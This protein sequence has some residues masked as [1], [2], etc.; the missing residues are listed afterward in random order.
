MKVKIY[1]E[2]ADENFRAIRVGDKTRRFFANEI[3]E[4]QIQKFL[5]ENPKVKI[6]HDQ[7]QSIAIVP[8][9]ADWN[10]TSTDIHW[11]MEKPC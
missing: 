8:K 6:K 11:E 3:P 10:T 5:D 1:S 9:T 7:F 2:R 4:G